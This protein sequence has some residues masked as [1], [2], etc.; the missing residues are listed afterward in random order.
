MNNKSGDTRILEVKYRDASD[1]RSVFV[2]QWFDGVHW[3]EFIK[4]MPS[5]PYHIAEF[6]TIEEAREFI[7]PNS[8]TTTY[9]TGKQTWGMVSVVD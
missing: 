5:S 4:H 6:K 9:S 1:W 3:H 8:Q 7:Q 2:P